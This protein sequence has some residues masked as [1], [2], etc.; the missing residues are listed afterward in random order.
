MLRSP[1][2]SNTNAPGQFVFVLILPMDGISEESSL[3]PLRAWL[4]NFEVS[5]Q[6]IKEAL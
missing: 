2:H 6:S 4:I 1:I 3:P 5:F